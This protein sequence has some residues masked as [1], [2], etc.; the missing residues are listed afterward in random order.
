[1]KNS[2]FHFA[3]VYDNG[4]GVYVDYYA[5]DP[6]TGRM[7]RF[8]TKFNRERTKR[9]KLEMAKRFANDVNDKLY[10]GWNPLLTQE[11]APTFRPL[12]EAMEHYMRQVERQVQDHTVRPDTL[13]AYKSFVANLMAW[14][15][16]SNPLCYEWDK[17]SISRFLDHIYLEKKNSARTRNNYL[18]FL[19]RLGNFMLENSYTVAN[20]AEGIRTLRQAEKVRT[21]LSISHLEALFAH[22]STPQRKTY[23]VLAQTVYY[24]LVR[25]TEITFLK[26][27]HFNLERQELTIQADFSK[28]RKTQT[29]SIP[30]PLM[31]LLKVH[32]A[33]AKEDAYAFSANDFKPGKRKL[34][35]KKISDTWSII[36]KELNFPAH[37]QFYSLKDTG[38]THMLQSGIPVL[39]V[40]D[41]ARHHDLSMTDKY[42][43]SGVTVGNP[44]I[45]A[46]GS[47]KDEA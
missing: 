19:R 16:P 45:L 6:A 43:R 26:V 9:Q 27:G 31:P 34:P 35:P 1:M 5:A 23:N 14:L 15:G 38:I 30:H 10:S 40:R 4:L 22:L 28:N 2:S 8:R 41:Q 33:G 11:E 42:V 20:P 29:I 25:R 18:N 7:I 3:Q 46:F 13:R 36:R 32:L 21:E 44:D 17:A 39:A 12:K 37:Y 24:C 47:T